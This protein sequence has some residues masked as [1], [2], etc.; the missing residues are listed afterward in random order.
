MMRFGKFYV[1]TATQLTKEDVRAII[2]MDSSNPTIEKLIFIET[3]KSR[4][5][6]RKVF[7]C[8]PLGIA[9]VKDVEFITVAVAQIFANQHSFA[10]ARMPFTDMGSTYRFWD[11][12]PIED[13]MDAD[14]LPEAPAEEPKEKDE[15]VPP[16]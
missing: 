14:P 8:Y 9:S 13:L 7:P 15:E 12:P 5:V 2:D 6:G 3:R 1:T 11:Y 4:N 16:Q 10:I